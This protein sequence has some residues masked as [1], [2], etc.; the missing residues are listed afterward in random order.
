MFR[1]HSLLTT[2]KIVGHLLRGVAEPNAVPSLRRR[3]GLVPGKEVV[4]AK[5][6]AVAAARARSPRRYRLQL[7]SARDLGQRPRVLA[8]EVAEAKG[9]AGA[10]AIRRKM[11]SRRSFFAPDE[12]RRRPRRLAEHEAQPV[13]SFNGC[14]VVFKHYTDPNGVY[15]PNWVM[16]C[17]NPDHKA[18]CHKRRG[19]TEAYE[20]HHGI[21]EP[22]A[23]L[24]EWADIPWPSRPGVKSHAL[25]NP[26]QEDVNRLVAERR[27]DLEEVARMAGR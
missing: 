23:F 14:K 6:A 21:I 27:A 7:L 5:G 22:L 4:E 9:A 18:G 12:E 25:E 10:E 11:A 16:W 26:S 13:E 19:A 3:V 15:Q 17:R 1:H 2:T 24:H 20:A 8:E